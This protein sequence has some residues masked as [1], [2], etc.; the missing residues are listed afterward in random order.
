MGAGGHIKKAGLGHTLLCGF[1]R[2][3][4]VVS[5]AVGTV[6]WL[7]VG[8]TRALLTSLSLVCLLFLFLRARLLGK[9]SSLPETR[10]ASIFLWFDA[11]LLTAYSD[12][13]RT[14]IFISM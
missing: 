4:A 10:I 1:L 12:F 11:S 7:S 9:F 6:P 2:V 3:M 14:H 5:P 13:C 8:L